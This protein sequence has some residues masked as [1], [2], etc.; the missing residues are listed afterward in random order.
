LISD[1]YDM[2]AICDFYTPRQ[3]L[4]QCGAA[5]LDVVLFYCA[6]DF[7]AKYPSLADF[8]KKELDIVILTQDR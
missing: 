3:F 1:A 8:L 4:N 2:K 6:N 5:G 7:I